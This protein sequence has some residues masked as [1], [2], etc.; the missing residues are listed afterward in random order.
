MFPNVPMSRL[1]TLASL[2]RP[3]TSP[4]YEIPPTTK[5]LAPP[6]PPPPPR[7]SQS[8]AVLDRDHS[9]HLSLREIRD[10]LELVGMQASSDDMLRDLYGL[11]TDGC[12]GFDLSQLS[13]VLRR[14]E[15]MQEEEI[16][17]EYLRPLMFDV[18]AAAAEK[19]FR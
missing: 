11:H 13:S 2:P 8:F 15:R 7:S 5:A 14:D 12:G 4:P 10:A 3:S 17:Y 18:R 19:M 16:G 6:P 9:G 1:S